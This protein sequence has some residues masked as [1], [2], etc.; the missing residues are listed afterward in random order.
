MFTSLKTNPNSVLFSGKKID[1]RLIKK[2]K[3]SNYAKDFVLSKLINI[4]D[5]KLDNKYKVTKWLCWKKRN[6]QINF[7]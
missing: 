1:E 7:K 6:I 5:I 4:V 3:K 2:F